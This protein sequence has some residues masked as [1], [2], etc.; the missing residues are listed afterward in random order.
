MLDHTVTKT[1]EL[2][3]KVINARYLED[4][5]ARLKRG[6]DDLSGMVHLAPAREHLTL[7]ANVRAKVVDAAVRL[8]GVELRGLVL[9]CDALTLDGA[10]WRLPSM[11]ELQSLI[12]ESRA[13]PAIDPEAFPATPSEGLW[14]GTAL[15]GV[16]GSAWF[17]SFDEGIAYNAVYEHPYRFRCVR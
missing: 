17:V 3:L 11:H 14:A 13:A 6:V 15:A 7:H 10:G 5:S 1:R 12:D 16:P 9:P 8:T 2:A 4:E